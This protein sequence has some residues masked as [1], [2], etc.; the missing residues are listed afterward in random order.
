M[1]LFYR[2]TLGLAVLEDRSVEGW[3]EFAAGGA[4]L[5]LHAIPTELVE[6]IV[7]THPPRR[8]EEAPVKLVFRVD[9][10]AAERT[11]LMA[12]RVPMQA[13]L[14]WGACDGTDPEGNVF[15]IASRRLTATPEGDA[16]DTRR[17]LSN[18][19][20]APPSDDIP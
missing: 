6:S 10:V 18:A 2:E 9:D 16:T 7:V 17:T 1:A 4:T 14:S 19:R 3:V 8:R 11:R 20:R 15:Q 5:V 12:L 13:L